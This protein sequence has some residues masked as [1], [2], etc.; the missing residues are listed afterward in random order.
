M[1]GECISLAHK[2]TRGPDIFQNQDQYDV[3]D[4]GGDDVCMGRESVTMKVVREYNRC[5]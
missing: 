4:W 1:N 2:L 5:G 3:A